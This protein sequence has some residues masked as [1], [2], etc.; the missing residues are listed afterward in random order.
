MN[1]D[2]LSLSD[3]HNS[4]VVLG[5][6]ATGKTSY[7]VGLAKELGGE[8]ISADSRQ[9][10]KGLD[11]GTGK[12]LKEYGD[13]PHHLIDI[14]T[15]EREYN[16]FDFQNSGDRHGRHKTQNFDCIGIK[17]SGAVCREHKAAVKAM[18]IIRTVKS[19][20][21]AIRVGS[22]IDHFA[23]NKGEIKIKMRLNEWNLIFFRCV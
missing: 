22:E 21:V 2:F 15:L 6:T 19:E 13:V 14:C 17:F 9:V 10:Y 18:P 3:K 16:V 7:S 20:S 11:L 4:V 8:I 1:L 23:R 12:D 5:A